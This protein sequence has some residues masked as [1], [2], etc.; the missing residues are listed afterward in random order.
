MSEKDILSHDLLTFS[1]LFS[2]DVSTEAGKHTLVSQ[3]EDMTPDKPVFD[4]SDPS[5]KAVVVDMLSVLRKMKLSYY[6]TLG[7]LIM[8]MINKV[9]LISR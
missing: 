4:P 5:P 3:L 6:K 1:P 7:E 9:V 8:S 2:G